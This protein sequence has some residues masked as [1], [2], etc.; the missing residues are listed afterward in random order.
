[1]LPSATCS[2]NERNTLNKKELIELLENEDFP[3]IRNTY[4]GRVYGLRRLIVIMLPNGQEV[5]GMMYGNNSGEYCR[6]LDD[7]N[8]FVIA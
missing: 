4:T 2:S 1:M 8:D 6:S 7:F 5:Q 3:S